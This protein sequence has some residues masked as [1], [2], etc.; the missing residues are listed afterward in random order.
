MEEAGVICQNMKE[1]ANFLAQGA[2]SQI[3]GVGVEP[4]MRLVNALLYQ[5]SVCA[6]LLE[7]WRF[8][9]LFI[10]IRLVS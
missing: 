4:E 9:Y 1:P 7:A 2:R 6:L 3:N 8:I 5:E 10:S